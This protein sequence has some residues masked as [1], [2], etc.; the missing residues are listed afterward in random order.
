MHK[1]TPSLWFDHQ[2]EDAMRV[3]KRIYASWRYCGFSSHPLLLMKRIVGLA[4]Y[5]LPLLSIP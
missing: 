5:E 3:Y 2:A 4:C 1:I